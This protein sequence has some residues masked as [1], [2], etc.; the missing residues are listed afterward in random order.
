MSY[1]VHVYA[2]RGSPTYE[3]AAMRCL[4]RFLAA[5]SPT[6]KHFAEIEHALSSRSPGDG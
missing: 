1:L 3:R 2:E 4:E 6:L 5:S